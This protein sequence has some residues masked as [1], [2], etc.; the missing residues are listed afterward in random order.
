MT[1]ES[2]NPTLFLQRS[3]GPSGHMATQ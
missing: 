2:Q 3:G 1:V